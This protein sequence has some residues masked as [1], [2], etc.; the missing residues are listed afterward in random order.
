MIERQNCIDVDRVLAEYPLTVDGNSCIY[1]DAVFFDLEHYI[2]KKP[3]CIGVFGCC[4]FDKDENKLKVTQ[5]MIENKN[6]A[7]AILKL[8]KDYFYLMSTKYNKKYIITFSG[9]NDFTVIK[10]LFEKYNI[11]L[12]IDN[13][14]VQIDLQKQYEK[15]KH[16]CIGLKALEKQFCIFRDS[17]IISGSNLAKTFSKIIKDSEYIDRMPQ[18]KKEKILLYNEQDV[19][20]LF[21]IYTNWSKVVYKNKDEVNE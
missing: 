12:N 3:I 8:A 15:D 6:D 17:E 2:Y 4:Y 11:D 13:Y 20:S 1:E 19:V 5:Y 18:E 9:N 21:H 14:F 16:E 7:K 10:Y